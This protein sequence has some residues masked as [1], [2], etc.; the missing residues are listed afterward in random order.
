MRVKWRFKWMANFNYSYD[1]VRWKWLD[2]VKFRIYLSKFILQSEVRIQVNVILD[3][4]LKF[5]ASKCL[6][7]YQVKP[8]A[9]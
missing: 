9:T 3:L 1:L 2:K 4:Y 5:V 7:F 6:E 8:T